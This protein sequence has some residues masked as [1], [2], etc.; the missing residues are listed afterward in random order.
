MPAPV[1]MSDVPAGTIVT[2]SEVGSKQA[3]GGRQTQVV[4]EALVLQDLVAKYSELTQATAPNIDK[5]K[6]MINAGDTGGASSY[7]AEFTAKS[8][9][10][11]T[12]SLNTIVADAV[13]SY[14]VEE[15]GMVRS[16]GDPGVDKFYFDTGDLT[17]SWVNG[18]QGK[19]YHCTVSLTAPFGLS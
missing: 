19:A 2:V 1:K 10:A 9:A 16:Q 18:G 7:L 4:T 5:V 14:L 6:K 8:L 13:A 15:H 11:S 12:A 17:V 3:A